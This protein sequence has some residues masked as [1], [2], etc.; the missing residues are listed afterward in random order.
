MAVTIVASGCATNPREPGQR[1]EAYASKETVH[2]EQRTVFHAI[3]R[4]YLFSEKSYEDLGLCIV[5]YE[6]TG[7]TSWYKGMD[8]LEG[9]IEVTA[10]VV[11]E[12]GKPQRKLWTIHHSGNEFGASHTYDPS[13]YI[14][15]WGC[16]DSPEMVAAF[17]GRTGMFKETHPKSRSVSSVAP[18]PTKG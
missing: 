7:R 4:E 16:C 13:V 18:G 17:D 3:S 14:T 8:G 10:W 2:G 1:A 11:N 9:E 12:K 15:K 5:R 6:V